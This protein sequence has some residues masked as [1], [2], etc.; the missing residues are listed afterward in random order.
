[1]IKEK[2]N[3]YQ[4]NQKLL[5]MMDKTENIIF[6]ENIK[7]QSSGLKADNLNPSIFMWEHPNIQ[8]T[9]YD[10]NIPNIKG[11][12][13]TYFY[14]K[15]LKKN[16]SSELYVFLLS[17]N[18]T[19]F[20]FKKINIKK[21]EI[22][23]W[24]FNL[25]IVNGATSIGYSYHSDERYQQKA[26]RYYPNS[27]SSATYFSL[28]KTIK[29]PNDFEDS[30]FSSPD[31]EYGNEKTYYTDENNIIHYFRTPIFP[32]YWRDLCAEEN[33]FD[34]PIILSVKD[35]LNFTSFKGNEIN[36]NNG[37]F[38]N[39]YNIIFGDITN[40][41]LKNMP[42]CTIFSHLNNESDGE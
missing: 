19:K 14:S 7:N 40:D 41:M 24:N 22:P 10:P 23:L 9:I 31:Y 21:E 27:P 5:N 20:L 28:Y 8:T 13:G 33:K 16:N 30:G 12:M 38:L 32:G 15:N 36:Q 1:M 25:T 17:P 3:A 29:F 11:N 34:Y 35:D 26:Y 2:D 39:K 37:I 18:K 4:I 6:T 42:H